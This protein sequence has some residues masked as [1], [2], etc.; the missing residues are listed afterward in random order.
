MT[1]EEHKV[2]IKNQQKAYKNAHRTISKIWKMRDKF[3]DGSV[4]KNGLENLDAELRY[5]IIK[6]DLALFLQEA[7]DDG[8]PELTI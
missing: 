8:Y 4:F 5:N 7:I 6:E 1:R 3:E 2:R